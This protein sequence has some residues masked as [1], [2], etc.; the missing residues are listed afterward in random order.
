MRSPGQS[1]ELFLTCLFGSIGR[2]LGENYPNRVVL[3]HFCGRRSGS[4]TISILPVPRRLL[5]ARLVVGRDY[6][7]TE[8]CGARFSI[9]GQTIQ[10]LRPCP[11]Q[12][13]IGWVVQS[14]VLRSLGIRW[15]G[16]VVRRNLPRQSFRGRSIISDAYSYQ[17]QDAQRRFASRT[18][19]A[20]S[21]MWQDI[22][23]DGAGSALTERRA[24]KSASC[25]SQHPGA[26]RG[27]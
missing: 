6:L 9:V 3:Q 16:L 5:R 2:L 13:K 19:G 26:E 17:R 23:G 7:D 24:L 10:Y 4:F 14:F 15:N 1:I 11:D 8:I 20:F 22:A 18:L 25:K 21:E 27:K 12:M